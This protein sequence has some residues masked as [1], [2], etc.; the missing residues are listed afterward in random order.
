MGAT[1]RQ[2]GAVLRELSNQLSAPPPQGQKKPKV[3]A[4]TRKASAA[5]AQ[6][7]LTQS[8]PLDLD[9]ELVEG[10][11]Q[12]PGEI[13]AAHPDIDA[14]FCC[15]VPPD[16]LAQTI[17]L[18]DLIA[19]RGPNGA[20][21]T[22]QPLKVRRFVFSSV[23]RGGDE[24]SWTNRTDVPHFTSKHDIEQ[25]LRSAWEEATAAAA[26]AAE[27]NGEQPPPVFQYTVIRPVAFYDN[28]NPTTPFGSLFASLLATMPADTPLQMVSVRD[29]GAFAARALLCEDDAAFEAEFAGRATGLAGDELTHAQLRATFARV[30]AAAGLPPS[31]QQLPQ[32]WWPVGRGARWAIALV[33]KMFD[34]FEREGYGVDLAE[35]RRREPGLQD[36]ETWL[37]ESSKFPFSREV[38]GAN[39][40]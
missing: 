8:P 9:L 6:A 27:K 30:A 7:L 40:E 28:L 4:L 17:S 29:V 25:H 32:S 36:F 34:W 15:T 11:T 24:R 26:A 23:E 37:R 16:E 3:L 1:G 38:A 18:I 35:L 14:V 12:R 13:F 33:G 21:G 22:A 2:G 10:D 5:K 39:K 19:G 20:A 31:Q